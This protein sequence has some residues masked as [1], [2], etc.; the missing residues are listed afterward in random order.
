MLLESVEAE[1]GNKKF[2][3]VDLFRTP[4]IRK[5]ALCSGIVW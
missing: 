5:L 4:N 1:N 2:T 3:F